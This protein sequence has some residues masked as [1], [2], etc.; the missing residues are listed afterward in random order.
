V[1]RIPARAEAKPGLPAMFAAALQHHQAGRPGDAELL[2]RRILAAD[3]RHADSLHLLGLLAH[4]TGRP[5]LAADLIGQAIAVNPGVAFFHSNLGS[6]LAAQSRLEAAIACFGRAIGLRPDYRE[7]HYNLGNALFRLG[8]PDA[9]ETSYR[10]AIGLRRDWPEAHNNLGNAVLEQGRPEEAAACFRRALELRAD[11][12]EAHN[13]L[14]NALKKKGLL[15]EAVECYRR[16]LALRPASPDAHNILA[17]ALQQQGRLDEAIACLRNSIGLRPDDPAAHNLLGAALQ[18]QGRLDEAVGCY[19]RAL[20]LRPDYPEALLN[21]GT[22]LQFQEELEEAVASYLRAI[23]LNPDSAAAHLNLGTAL[24]ELGRM[25]AAASCHRR[26]IALRP[27]DPDGHNNLGAALQELGLLD[28]AVASH[29]RSLELR[30]DYPEAHSNLGSALRKLGRLDEAVACFGRALELR[31]DN[32]EAH[33]NFGHAQQEQGRLDEALRYYAKA[34]EIRPDYPAAHSNLLFAHNYLVDR[35]PQSLRD[36]ARQFGAGLTGRV[37]EAFTGWGPWPAGGKLRV[38]LVSGDLRNHPVG[39]FLESLLRAADPARIEFV[40]FP[41]H[42]VEDDLTARLRPQVKAW[43]PIHALGDAAAA[44]L[45]HGER[46]QV[47]LDLSG[48]TGR[49]RLGVFAWR[50]APVQASWLGYFSTTGVAEIDYI[51]GDPQVCPADEGDH[52]TETVWRL[53]EIYL[54]FTP[55]ALPVEISP[56]PALAGGGLTFGCFNNLAKINDAVIAVW[57]R[58]LRAVPGSRLMLKARQFQ[59]A[60]VTRALRARFAA[61]GIGEDRLLTEKP[62]SR[63]EYLRAYHR[64]DIALD[65]FP[66]PGGTTSCEALWMGVPVLTRRGDRFLSHAGETILRNAGLPGWIAA[67]DDAYVAKAADFA[68]DLGG[69]AALRGRLRAQVLASPLFDA[70]RFARHFEEAMAGMWQRWR[71]GPAGSR[72]AEGCTG[73]GT[74]PGRSGRPDAQFSLSSSSSVSVQASGS[75]SGA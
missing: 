70:P 58:L 38:G 71:A 44:R 30:P 1:T 49:N 11:Y 41:A 33:N 28:E 13:N 46:V 40:A 68:A 27:D 20:E 74:F 8:R 14:G 47:L 63:A 48:H 69:L 35:S 56:L 61:H 50:P 64:I 62:S 55:P 36:L 3:P 15:D 73:E 39:Y 54:C 51:L 66:Y 5:D 29:R 12:A 16:A 25:E 17:T 9:A 60:T 53:P 67:D 19:R 6:V 7:A 59:D 21:L 22:A 72:E 26:A 57:S 45:I 65:P 18:L 24:Q 32:A 4:Q 10:R 43:K 23:E 37:S 42:H 2:C 34:L 31:P 75:G 52:F